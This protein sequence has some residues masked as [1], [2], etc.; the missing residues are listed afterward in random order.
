VFPYLPTQLRL[1]TLSRIGDYGDYKVEENR[2]LFATVS[3]VLGVEVRLLRTPIEVRAAQREQWND[4][5]NFLAVSPGVVLGYDR[6]TTTNRFLAD[7]GIQVVPVVGSELGRGRGGPR[8]MTCP[9][10]KR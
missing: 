7:Q 8:C 6:N 4:S 1:F 3:D 5:N 2:E 10:E 9:I